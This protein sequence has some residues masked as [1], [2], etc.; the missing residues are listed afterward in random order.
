MT[1]TGSLIADN[2][3]DGALALGGGIAMENG[4]GTKSTANV[5]TITDT[6]F[7]GNQVIGPLESNGGAIYSDPYA[8]VSVSE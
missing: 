8:S 7:A 5:L 1:V 3:A 2:T 6:T 4:A